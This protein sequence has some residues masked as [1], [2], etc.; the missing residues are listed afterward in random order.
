[1]DKAELAPG[2]AFG[3]R[4]GGLHLQSTEIQERSSDDADEGEGSMQPNRNSDRSQSLH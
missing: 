2:M 3:E 1:M 4:I